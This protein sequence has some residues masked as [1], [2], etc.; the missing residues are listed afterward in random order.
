MVAKTPPMGWNSWDCYGAAVNEETVRKNAEFMAKNLK[1]YGWQYVVVDIQWYEPTANNHEYHNF[2]ELEMDEFSRVIPAVNRF[3]SAKDGRGFTALAEY[4]HSLGL[5]FGV[6]I[7]RGIPR[8]AVHKNTKIKGTNITARQ[9]AAQHSVCPWNTDMYGVDADKDGAKQY[10]DS[11]YEMFSQ[12]GVDFVK[13]DDI[14]NHYAYKEIELIHNAIKNSGREMVLS[15]SPGPTP[16]DRAE[17]LKQ[18]VN[19][20]R[21]T[22]DFW[23]KWELLYDMFWRADMWAKHSVCGHWPDADM[24][25]IGPILQDYDVNNFTKFTQD[26]Q[27]TMMTLWAM[28]RSPLMIGGEMT[29]FDEFT[30]SLLTNKELFVLLNE[31]QNA[32]QL[33]RRGEKGSEKI[34]W[35]SQNINGGNYIALFNAGEIDAEISVNLAD[36]NISSDEAYDIWTGSHI[37]IND[38]LNVSVNAH[39]AKLFFI[40]SVS[41][42]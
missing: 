30:M 1:E 18:Y 7:M 38:I 23:D 39:G 42:F 29:R 11:M 3:P 34:V 4:V 21:I 33:F 24:L 2:T 14:A 27:I 9:I 15:I 13:V 10:Y 26:E 22:D 20:W 36:Y 19:M 41:Q 31:S 37:K 28:M 25:P 6:H 16:I 5:K 35:Y 8:Q 32:R 12:W 17:H 40:K